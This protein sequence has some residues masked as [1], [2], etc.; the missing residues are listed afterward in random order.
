M[1]VGVLGACASVTADD[2]VEARVADWFENTYATGFIDGDPDFMDHYAPSVHLVI[3]QQSQ[4]LDRD[5]LATAMDVAYVQPWITKGWVTTKL[6][7]VA[8]EQLGSDSARATAAWAFLDTDG[9]N[10][11]GCDRPVWH[12]VLVHNGDRWQI[13]AEIEGGCP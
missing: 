11:V 7:D 1:L 12:Y 8:V 4:I 6:L 5:A 9:T 2:S 13:I 10:V 3:G